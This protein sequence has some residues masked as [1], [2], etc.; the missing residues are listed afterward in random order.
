MVPPLWTPTLENIAAE[1]TNNT[2]NPGINTHLVPNPVTSPKPTK[3]P[4]GLKQIASHNRPGLQEPW[5]FLQTTTTILVAIWHW[6]VCLK[7]WGGET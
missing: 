2:G 6:L 7:H 1:H 3:I 4:L 5:L